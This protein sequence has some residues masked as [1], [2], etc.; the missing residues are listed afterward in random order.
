[1]AEIPGAANIVL[2]FIV[3]SAVLQ[4]ALVRNE[5]RKSGVWR[6]GPLLAIPRVAGLRKS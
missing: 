3:A 4:V 5:A 2:V 6:H 1:M